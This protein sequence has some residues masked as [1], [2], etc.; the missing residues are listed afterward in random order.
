[1]KYVVF[2]FAA[3]GFVSTLAILGI[4]L[5]IYMPS[6]GKDGE[7]S[8]SRCLEHGSVVRLDSYYDENEE[9][10]YEL[11]AHTTGFS[12]KVT[13]ITLVKGKYFASSSN[14]IEQEKVVF[15]ESIYYG[16]ENEPEVQWPAAIHV[17][18]DV[19]KIV[20]TKDKKESS[21]LANVH[22]SWN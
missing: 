4:L 13:Y 16:E 8:S 11:I 1:M 20:Y 5:A 9:S 6:N 10:M 17:S 14:C 2:L 7:L 3:I 18:G 19:V 12:D 15:S 22:I 21:R